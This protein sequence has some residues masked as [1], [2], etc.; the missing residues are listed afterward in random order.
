MA[1]K[2]LPL[3]VGA[4]GGKLDM[5]KYAV[6]H[7]GQLAVELSQFVLGHIS[8]LARK[9]ITVASSTL[10]GM[11][12]SDLGKSLWYVGILPVTYILRKEDGDED[13]INFLK[14]CLST[15]KQVPI[16]LVGMGSGHWLTLWGYDDDLGE[17]YVFDTSKGARRDENGLTT[18][19]YERL[20]W[21]WGRRAWLLAGVAWLYRMFPSL[22]RWLECEPYTVTVAFPKKYPPRH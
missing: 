21:V 20:L 12:P 2:I 3:P 1:R 8:R 18:Y 13:K 14:D 19:S 16:L 10:G 6:F 17:F 4:D 11:L 15:G 22:R 9:P 7:C 5:K